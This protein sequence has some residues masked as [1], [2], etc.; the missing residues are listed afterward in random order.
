MAL[1]DERRH[2][3][4]HRV[5]R[6]RSDPAGVRG[7]AQARSLG[8]KVEAFDE[9]GRAVVGEVGELVLT[10]PLR[11]C[12]S[13]SG[14]TRRSAIARATSRC[15]RACGVTETGSRS[16]RAARD[17]PRPL[18]RDDQPRRSPHRHGRDLRA[19]LSRAEIA[20][21]LAVDPR[22]QPDGRCCCSSSCARQVL[23]DEL[24]AKIRRRIR[25][26]C[27][28]RHVPD[29]IH[30]VPAIPRTLSGKLLE[31]P[32]KRILMGVPP[33]QAGAGTRWQ[34]RGARLLRPLRAAPGQGRSSRQGRLPLISR[35]VPVISLHGSRQS[36]R[37]A[38]ERKAV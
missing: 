10:E 37:A 32:V 4:V 16:P 27:S 12:R 3:R 33:E 5:R 2:R 28:P 29:E 19:V 6:R 31:V 23:T 7:R 1:L 20:D 14:T 36:P 8:A 18:R 17:H 13:T 24:V 25:E 35:V 15:I 30:S 11:R 21:A 26:D 34:P 22:A 9:H 38:F